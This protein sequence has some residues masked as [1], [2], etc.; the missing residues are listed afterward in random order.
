[1]IQGTTV[2]ID[3]P[4]SFR[5]VQVINGG[6]LTHTANTTTQTHK[7]DLTV[8]EQV[9]VDATSKIDVSGKGYLPGRTT[10]NTTEGGATGSQWRQL[11]R[12]GR[13]IRCQTQTGVRGLRGPERLGQWR[14]TVCRWFRRRLGSDHR[15]ALALNRALYANPTGHGSGGG[16][17][18]SVT[19]LQGTGW[20]QVSLAGRGGGGRLAIYAADM[21]GLDPQRSAPV[22]IPGERG[23][24][25][26][27]DTDEPYGSLIIDN[28]YALKRVGRH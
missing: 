28:G 6:V 25:Y 27:R 9:I 17:Y 24:V 16:I 10:G 26:L 21:S 19:T 15:R 11:R 8:A 12:V 13:E 5:S 18:I 14:W 2:A 1:M 20:M 22:G 23:T 4:H 3:G 7:L